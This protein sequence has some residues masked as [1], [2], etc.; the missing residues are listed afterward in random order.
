MGAFSGPTTAIQLM[1]TGSMNQPLDCIELGPADAASACIWLHGLGAD[2]NDFA[3]LIPELRLPH[4][5]FVLPHAPVRPITINGGM[6][7]RG[8]YDILR[9]DIG[10]EADEDAAGIDASRRE[11]ERLIARERQRGADK[12]LLA[13]FS[14]GGAVVL[15]TGLR[16]DQPLAGI[17]ALSTYLPLAAGLE[18]GKHAANQDIPIFQAHG[19]HDPVIAVEHARASRDHLRQAGYAVDYRE[20]PMAHAVAPEEIRDIAAFLKA[21]L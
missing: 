6:A 20:Y 7:M 9:M 16:H 21:R 18:T 13:G 14:Q 8:W 3:P 17:L 4:V 2:G 15:H 19:S 1:T 5:R 12:I 11:V 10:S